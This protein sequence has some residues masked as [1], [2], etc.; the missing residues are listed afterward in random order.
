MQ[1]GR[2]LI[3]I[4]DAAQTPVPAYIH[5]LLP[6]MIVFAECLH[7]QFDKEIRNGQFDEE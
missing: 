4:I 7:K 5:K 6:H 3:R 2:F 1:L